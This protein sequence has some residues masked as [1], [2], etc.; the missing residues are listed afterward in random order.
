MPQSPLSSIV[1]SASDP[2]NI[3]GG[4]DRPDETTSPMKHHAAPPLSRPLPTPRHAHE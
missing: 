3:E 4:G 2:A 1:G